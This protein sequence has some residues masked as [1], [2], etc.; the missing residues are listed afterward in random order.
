MK[1]FDVQTVWLKQIENRQKTVEGRTG[2]LQKYIGLIGETIIFTD[3]NI[4][5][6]VH[7][8]NV[9][10]FNTLEEYIDACG[11][12]N[13]APH[14]NSREETI[15]AYLAIRDDQDVQIFAPERIKKREGICALHVKRTD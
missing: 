5:F 7:V 3:G 15:V 12:Q 11:W 13:V 14:L 6:P 1:S 4:K 9:R 8:Q 2:N 10:H